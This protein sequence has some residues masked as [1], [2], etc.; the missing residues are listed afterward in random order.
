MA[1]TDSIYWDNVYENVF[2]VFNPTT[3]DILTMT[4]TMKADLV[5][6]AV[7]RSFDK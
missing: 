2:R 5:H 7:A 6:K 3:D 4:S 1:L